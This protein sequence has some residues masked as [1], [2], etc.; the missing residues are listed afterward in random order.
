MSFAIRARAAPRSASF[1][2][3]PASGRLAEPGLTGRH[4]GPY[5]ILGEA[6]HGGMRVVYEAEDTRLGRR[7]ALKLLPA[8]LVESADARVRFEREARAAS[9]LN[10]PHICAIQDIGEYD[11][12]PFLVMERMQGETLKHAIDGGRCR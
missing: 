2:S 9:A 4:I 1:L 6:G 5:R 11:A 7:V 8:S 3:E 10:H 12:Q